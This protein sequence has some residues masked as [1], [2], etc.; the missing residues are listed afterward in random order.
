MNVH[1]G[2][3]SDPAKLPG[4]AH[5]CEH[6]L[7]LGTHKFPDEKEYKRSSEYA[8]PPFLFIL[9]LI[10]SYPFLRTLIKAAFTCVLHRFLS[11]HGGSSNAS[12]GSE[13]TNYFFDVSANSLSGTRI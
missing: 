4:L 13:H 8:P 3:M 5:F 1:I 6:M 11:Q 9:Q 7:F 12:T 2:N 10:S